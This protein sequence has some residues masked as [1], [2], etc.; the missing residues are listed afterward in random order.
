MI[1]G[2]ITHEPT[3]V[4]KDCYSLS[5]VAESGIQYLLTVNEFTRNNMHLKQGRTIQATGPVYANPTTGVAEINPYNLVVIPMSCPSTPRRKK[6]K[7]SPRRKGPSRKQCPQMAFAA[8][9]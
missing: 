1:T 7:R 9:R 5:M 3:K 6:R 4:G 2:T 8:L